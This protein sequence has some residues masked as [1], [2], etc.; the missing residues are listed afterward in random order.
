MARGFNLIPGERTRRVMPGA[1]TLPTRPGLFVTLEGGEGAGKSTQLDRLRRRI[2][3]AGHEAVVTREPGGTPRAEAI[4]EVLLSGAG[5]PHGPLAEAIL[6][7]AARAD[8]VEHL[9]RP[10]LARGGVVVCDRFLDS[11]RV[12]QGALG[13]VAAPSL[14]SLERLAVAD[15]LPDLTLIFDLPAE[16]GLDRARRRREGHEAPDRFER[17]ALLFHQNVREAFRSIA[18]DEPS[19]CKIVDAQGSPDEVEARAWSLV[20]TRLDQVGRAHGA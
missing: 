12:Y 4:R 3:A 8:H 10:I 1:E 2:E 11:T 19:R 7:A 9:I 18:G 17:E 14:A 13:A 5:K 20:R 6:F 15:L 16:L